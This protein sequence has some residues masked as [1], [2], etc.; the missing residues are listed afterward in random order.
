VHAPSEDKSD[1]SKIQR[2]FLR[3]IKAVPPPPPPPP[4]NHMKILFG[5]FDAKVDRENIFKPTVCNESLQQDSNDSGAKIVNFAISKNPAIKSTMFP[6]RNIHKY[7]WTS[8]GGKS[9]NHIDHIL[10][11][12]R[13]H[14]SVRDVRSL[15]AADCDTDHCLVVVKI[16]EILAVSKQAGQGFD[17]KD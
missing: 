10:I 16:M 11:N 8:P 2:Q 7:T 4:K 1:E 13:W 5:E 6:L 12:S 14:P 15:R 3:G 17:G 9:H